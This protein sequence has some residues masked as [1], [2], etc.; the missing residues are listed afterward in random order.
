MPPRPGYADR[1]FTTGLVAY[2]GLV[3]IGDDKN[4]EPVIQKA[5][6]LGGYAEDHPMQGINGGASVTTGFGWGTVLGAAGQVIEAV[7]SGKLRPIFLV[8]GCDGTRPGRNYFTEFVEVARGHADPDAGLRQ[9]PLQRPGVGTVEG[10]PRLMD[11]GSATT[12]SPPQG[13][14]GAGGRL[15]LRRQRPAA[16]LGALLVE[17]KAVAILLTLLALGVRNIRLG[18]TLPALCRRDPLLSGR[19]LR[20]RATH[21]R[22]GRPQGDPG[23]LKIRRRLSTRRDGSA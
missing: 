9:V 23:A 1:V 11:M 20:H 17:Q 15:R 14:G 19:A 18:P 13:G 2:P 8:G 12:R 7:K 21:H 10:L 4:F 16:D 6:E 3:K 5:L 22:R